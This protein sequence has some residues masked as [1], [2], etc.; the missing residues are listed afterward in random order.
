MLVG[1]FWPSPIHGNLKLEVEIKHKL[2]Y[3]MNVYSNDTK[4]KTK[5]LKDNRIILFL[6]AVVV[7]LG[8][9]VSPFA[10]AETSTQEIARLQA[11]NAQ[12]NKAVQSLAEQAT[13]YEGAIN[14]LAASVSALQAKINDNTA[15][16]Q[17][18]AQQIAEAEAELA[19][20]RSLLGQN[21]KAMYLEGDISTLEM[22][23]SSNDISDFVDKQQ[24][25]NTVKD[26]IKTTLDKIT[27]LKLQ[28]GAQ[29][30]AVD[31]LLKEQAAQQAQLNANL[32]EQ[33]SLLNYNQAQRDAFN[34]KTS[35]NRKRID[36]L[37]AAQRRAN[38][39]VDGG[40]YFLR[41]SGTAQAVN[42]GSYPY[43]NAGFGMSPGPG[44]VD[45]DGPDPWGYCT[46]Q[47]VSYAAWA[48]EASGRNAPRY[49]GNAK[50]WVA[51]AYRHPGD[52][53]V[54][55]TPQAGDVAISTSGY[56]GHAMY[57]E[58]VS[59]NTFRTSE[60]NTYLNGQLSYQTRSY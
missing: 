12:N 20:Q 7:G 55:R 40:Y 25:R 28:L 52:V 39:S 50:D 54:Y 6:L 16:Q 51:A 26:K 29:K 57:V 53:E 31:Q 4:M 46:R 8:F 17:R 32:Y 42:P 30:Q 43:R 11:E 45:N 18:L 59:G 5:A 37:I 36:E 60:Y 27:A 23:A 38:F 41:F 58:S 21:I 14:A 49:Y 19:K 22:L 9:I 47:C 56:W 1:V 34:A 2:W 24:Y 33:Q 13:S 3:H 35:Q 15:Q 48:V 44:C 10:N